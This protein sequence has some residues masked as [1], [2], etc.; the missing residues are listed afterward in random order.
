METAP[1]SDMVDIVSPSLAVNEESRKKTVN[2]DS[3]PSPS[4]TGDSADIGTEQNELQTAELSPVLP[5]PR[6]S[7]RLI[8]PLR[9]LEILS[10]TEP[11]QYDVCVYVSIIFILSF[12]VYMCFRL[13]SKDCSV[14]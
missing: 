4:A 3:S 1:E 6:C 8:K 12:F 14:S 13:R 10:L 2:G 5:G 7:E 11:R 9:D